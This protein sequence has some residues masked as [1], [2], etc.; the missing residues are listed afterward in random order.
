MLYSVI[1][2]AGKGNIFYLTIGRDPFS[3][4]YFQV[5]AVFMYVRKVIT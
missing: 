3:S 5:R 4:K 1:G 2:L